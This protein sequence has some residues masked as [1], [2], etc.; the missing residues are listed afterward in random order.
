[1]DYGAVATDPAI[2]LGVQFRR[3]RG[4]TPG[5]WLVVH[6]DGTIVYEG[7]EEDGARLRLSRLADVLRPRLRKG[8]A[9]SGADVLALWPKDAPASLLSAEGDVAVRTG[10]SDLGLD[11]VRAG[12]RDNA[13]RMRAVARDL[14]RH[15]L[16]MLGVDTDDETKVAESLARKAGVD[17][18]L[19]TS[20]QLVPYFEQARRLDKA[21]R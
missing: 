21:A 1:M 10:S 20:R 12:Q 14:A 6:V 16:S 8:L 5:A 3:P 4:S 17:P 18:T 15:E 2:P 19:A 11:E 7:P 13:R 9:T